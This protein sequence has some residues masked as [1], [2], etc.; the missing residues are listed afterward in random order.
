MLEQKN[1]PVS[2][3]QKLERLQERL[4]SIPFDLTEARRW[5]RESVQHARQ[6]FSEAEESLLR[7]GGISG[8]DA[9]RSLYLQ[10]RSYLART[11]EDVGR[12]WRED[13]SSLLD[14]QHEG[15]YQNYRIAELRKEETTSSEYFLA[16]AQDIEDVLKGGSLKRKE[17]ELLEEKAKR[18][19]QISQLCK[20]LDKRPVA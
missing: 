17:R 10:Q 14:M 8:L 6:L 3:V 2:F 20:E 13:G 9:A 11:L 4:L 15:F 12:R 5:D 19:K 18:Y 1:L 16:E 7:L